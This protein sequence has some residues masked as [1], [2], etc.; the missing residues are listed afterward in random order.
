M[1]NAFNE[2]KTEIEKM[3][4]NEFISRKDKLIKILEDKRNAEQYLKNLENEERKYLE[5][6]KAIEKYWI[7]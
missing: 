6:L 2:R 3:L 1:Y 7:E 5:T 4:K